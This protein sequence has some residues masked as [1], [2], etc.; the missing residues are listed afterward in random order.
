MAEYLD[1]WSINLNDSNTEPQ[2]EEL[3]VENEILDNSEAV[4]VNVE[5]DS[6]FQNQNE[7]QPEKILKLPM[8]RIK[9]I[10][11]MDPDVSLASQEAVFL[12]TKATE[13][14][15]DSLAKEAYAY[16]A[17]ENKKTVLKRHL[18]LAIHNIDALAFLDGTLE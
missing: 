1:E 11:K 12:I 10:M 6:E 14:M 8:G 2:N 16:T 9:K 3:D 18:D 17:N 15:L 13:L 7:E 5:G 4:D